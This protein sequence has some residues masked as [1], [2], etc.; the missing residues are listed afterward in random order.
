MTNTTCA[1]GFTLVEVLLAAF[2]VCIAIAGGVH[3]VALATMQTTEASRAW[4]ARALAQSRLEE[5]RAAAWTYDP[6][7]APLSSADLN[8]S[9]PG[10]LSADV[11]GFF[12]ALGRYG[13][14]ASADA[15][16]YRRRWAIEPSAQDADTLT[17]HVCVSGVGP[18][19]HARP[20]VCVWTVKT[21]QP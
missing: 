2:I 14:P 8:P 20:D 12:D 15:M 6:G 3:L 18:R 10:A 7:G 13:E 4:T 16:H 1:A 19:A 9:P 17:L 21:R 11:A 5:L